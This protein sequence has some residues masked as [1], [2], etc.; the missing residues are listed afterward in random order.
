MQ[1]Y[2]YRHYLRGIEL[3]LLLAVVIGQMATAQSQSGARFSAATL[4]HGIEAYLRE[5]IAESDEIA[6]VAPIEEVR[7][8]RSGVVAFCRTPH[9]RLWGLT[10]VEVSFQAD[11][12]ELRKIRVP[13]KITARRLVPIAK[14]PLQRGQRVSTADVTY[15]LQDATHYIE[16]LPDSVI[17]MQLA[18]SVTAGTPLLRTYLLGSGGIRAGEIV[19][20]VFRSGAITIRTTAQALQNADV[21]SFVKVRRNDTGVVF[22]GRLNDRKTVVVEPYPSSSSSPGETP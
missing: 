4:Q 19:T 16:L 11:G 18:Q 3:V 6:F 13:V 22:V 10:E 21:G 12:R 14:R 1:S 9:D 20:L 7:F 8:D 17:G 15:Q 5:R 2:R